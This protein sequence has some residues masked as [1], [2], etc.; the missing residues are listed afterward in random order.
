MKSGI[1]GV[2][3]EPLRNQLSNIDTYTLDSLASQYQSIR[4]VKT[5]KK[6]IEVSDDE[7][8]I[9]L[10]HTNKIW[11]YLFWIFFMVILILMGVIDG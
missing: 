9:F 5:E 11:P 1:G 2:E 10:N 4:P 6:Q 3:M 7:V 8:S